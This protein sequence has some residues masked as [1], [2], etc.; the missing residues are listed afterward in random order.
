ME[1]TLDEAKALMKILSHE[2]IPREPEDNYFHLLRLINGLQRFIDD[3]Q[4]K[5]NNE[6]KL[7]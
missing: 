1:I 7:A 3:N 6:S 5:K 2:W 4:V